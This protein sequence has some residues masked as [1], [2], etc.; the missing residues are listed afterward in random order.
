MENLWKISYL[1]HW[2]HLPIEIL[3]WEQEMDGMFYIE[4]LQ[5]TTE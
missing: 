3:F 2:K 1:K 5:C 4:E